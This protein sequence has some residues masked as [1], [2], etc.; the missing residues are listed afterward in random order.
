M[1]PVLRTIK[2]TR[3]KELESEKL[4]VQLVQQRTGIDE[5][6]IWLAVEW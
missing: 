1:M 5:T 2:V 3:L 4:F 6:Y